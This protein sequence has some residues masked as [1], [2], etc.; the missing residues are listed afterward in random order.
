MLHRHPIPPSAAKSHSHTTTSLPTHPL[1]PTQQT[2]THTTTAPP[3][4][5]PPPQEPSPKKSLLKPQPKNIK[6][7]RKYKTQTLYCTASY[8]PLGGISCG[9]LNK[10]CLSFSFVVPPLQKYRS[11]NPQAAI[12]KPKSSIPISQFALS[13]DLTRPLSAAGMESNRSVG[14][15]V[16]QSIGM[17]GGQ[18][19][20]QRCCVRAGWEARLVVGSAIGGCLVLSRGAWMAARDVATCEVSIRFTAG[21]GRIT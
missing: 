16:A 10:P 9:I 6:R 13:L 4:Q 8:P 12:L 15:S 17:A 14:R 21:G 11:A 20:S 3:P 19:D 5:T 7:E 1:P 2:H 18:S